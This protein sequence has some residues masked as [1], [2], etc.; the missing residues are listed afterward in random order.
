MVINMRNWE[1]KLV[2]MEVPNKHLF[3][4]SCK[5]VAL[6]PR[7]SKDGH[8]CFLVLTEDDG[9]WFVSTNSSSSFWIDDL[10][11]QLTRAKKWMKKNALKEG[12]GHRFKP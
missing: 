2:E 11:K 4:G 7:G 3:L 8:I 9:N 1:G 6:M 10:I 12:C 5:G